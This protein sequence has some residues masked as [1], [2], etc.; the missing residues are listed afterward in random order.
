MAWTTAPSLNGYFVTE[1]MIVE[2]VQMNLQ[3]IVH[4]VRKRVISNVKIED[5]F[6]NAGS[7]IS[8][9]TVEITPMSKMIFVQTKVTENVPN[10]SSGVL[11][12]HAF[13]LDGNVIMMTIAEMDRTR[14]NVQII[15][16]QQIGSNVTV[17][18]VSKKS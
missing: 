7:V 1:K 10:R 18:I 5:V 6:Q 3:K 2:M 8:K 13:L 12:Q 4:L 15:H 14:E 9:T 17:D 11:T 16:A